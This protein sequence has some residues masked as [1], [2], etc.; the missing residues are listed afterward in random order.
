MTSLNSFISDGEGQMKR[1]IAALV[2]DLQSIRTGR[3]NSGLVENIIIDQYN[4]KMPLNQL[5]SI[6]VSDA[7]MITIEPWDKSSMENIEKGIQKA[8]IGL[9]PSNDGRV[10]RLPIPPLTEERR[11]SLAKEVRKKS[12][13][14]RISIRNTRRKVIEQIR[15]LEAS[16]GCSKDESFSSQEKTQRLTDSYISKLDDLTKE[17]EQ[18]VMSI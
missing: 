1:S 7:R 2:K 11:S 3:A 14:G 13:D 5:A 8:D 9:S 16:K 10:I 18:D 6:T 15:Q 12:E 4:T 17:K